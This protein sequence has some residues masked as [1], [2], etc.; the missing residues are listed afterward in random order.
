MLAQK[1]F[2]MQRRGQRLRITGQSDRVIGHS[3]YSLEDYRVVGGAGRIG[4]PAERPVAGHQRGRDFARAPLAHRLDQ[5]LPGRALVVLLDLRLGQCAG[6]RDR[7]RTEVGV[8]G[9][10]HGDVAL[11]LRERDRGG[12]V[13]VGDAADAAKREVAGAVLRWTEIALERVKPG[14]TVTAIVNA[15]IHGT[16]GDVLKT[17]IA[18]KADPARME[19]VLYV[20]CE[21]IRHL[22]VLTQPF[23]PQAAGR[24]LDQLGVPGDRRAFRHLG[25][26]HALSP[27]TPLPKP[28]GVFPRF[29]EPE[30]G[31]ET[32]A[33]GTASHAG[34]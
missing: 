24:L 9:A 31:P 12:G 1:M 20:L 30:S 22:A 5:R 27:G 8:G 23:V 18:R 28:E 25:A 6:E 29:V 10:E 34:R 26:D 16:M 11:S 19:T 4:S 32:A 3:S 7:P 2:L 17:A 15:Y 21:T 13:G 33:A 14:G